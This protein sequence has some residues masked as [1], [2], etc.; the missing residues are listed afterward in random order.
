MFIDFDI[1]I[2]PN[3]P[4]LILEDLEEL[5]RLYDARGIGVILT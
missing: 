5:Q 4:K 1:P 3:P 2:P